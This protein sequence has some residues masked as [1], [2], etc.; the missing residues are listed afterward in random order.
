[1]VQF[2]AGA[3]DSSFLQYFETESG[4]NKTSVHCV[5]EAFPVGGKAADH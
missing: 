5:L 1:M 4:P 3:R 2:L